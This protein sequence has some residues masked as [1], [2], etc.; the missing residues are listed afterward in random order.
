MLISD[1]SR[2]RKNYFLNN[3]GLGRVVQSMVNLTKPLVEDLL[4]L[5]LLIKLIAIIFL[6]KNCEELLHWKYFSH[7]FG[8]N[9]RF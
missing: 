6:L 2:V 9:R 8:E 1:N 3:N 7:F 5:T 4:S